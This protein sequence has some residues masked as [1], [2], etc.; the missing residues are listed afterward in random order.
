MQAPWNRLR[1]PPD[2]PDKQQSEIRAEIESY[3][4]A[5][6]E[7]FIADGLEP[8]EARQ[9]AEKAFGDVD[10]IVYRCVTE[11]RGP[12]QSK[13]RIEF[14]HKIIH[15]I[16]YALR[17]FARSPGFTAVTVLTLAIGIGA[18]TA[19]FSV[20]SG[21]LLQP[22]PYDEPDDLVAIH[23]RFTPESGM[24]F[25]KYAVGSPEYFDY[26]DQNETMAQVAA[27]STEMVTM[28]A[29]DGGPE[30]VIGGLVSSS[31][32]SVLRTPPLIGRTLIA[33]DDGA[34]PAPV[35]VLGHGLWR[36]RFGSDSSIVGQRIRLGM[37]IAEDPV[38][39]EIVGVMPLSF[40]FP[41]PEVDLWA[42]LP[43]DRART[44]RGGHWFHL[45][46]RLAPGVSYEQADAEME[47]M[48]TR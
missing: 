31:M 30:M 6:A 8:E 1:S 10:A 32:F 16:R 12:G 47:T 34:Q 22:M 37:E 25:P 42:P 33:A 15:D 24:D 2:L 17:G 9:S 38:T 13:V 35:V 14:M 26:V 3:L 28:T 29:G 46:G 27:V 7:E 39:V 19:I 4:E 5:R 23:T 18:N 11:S 21:V 20:V 45:I 48:M 36:R 44:W 43:L 40:A 41:Y